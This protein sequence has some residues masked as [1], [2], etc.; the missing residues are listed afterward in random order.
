[1]IVFIAIAVIC[2]TTAVIILYN[3]YGMPKATAGLGFL[4]IA[5]IA[6]AGPAVFRKDSSKYVPDE[7]DQLIS[8]NSA[9]A[10]FATA[11]AVTGFAC[12]LPLEF[13]GIKATIEVTWLPM[14]FMAAGLS[15]FF[16]YSVAILIQYGRGGKEN[17]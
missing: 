14:I 13:L 12:M 5:G 10:G 4:G 9:T 17:E 2:A 16:A 15:H 11:Y 7:R 1:M 6:G 8:K 3:K